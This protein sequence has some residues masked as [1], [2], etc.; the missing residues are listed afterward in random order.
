MQRDVHAYLPPDAQSVYLKR[1]RE[2]AFGADENTCVLKRMKLVDQEMA[3]K[4]E[5][6]DRQVV[7]YMQGIQMVK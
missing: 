6:L 1:T 3:T 5:E 2:Q 7:D 4:A